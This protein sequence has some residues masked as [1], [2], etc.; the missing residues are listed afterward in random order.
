M[1]ALK[2]RGI[3]QRAAHGLVCI[4]FFIFF[5]FVVVIVFVLFFKSVKES[6]LECYSVVREMA[7]WKAS[8]PPRCSF[9]NS[10]V[11]P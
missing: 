5:F 4:S 8:L 3:L 6:G 2:F 1:V 10:C 7:D 9:Q 11:D